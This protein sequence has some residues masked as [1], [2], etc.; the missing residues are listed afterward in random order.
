MHSVVFVALLCFS[1]AFGLYRFPLAKRESVKRQIIE[2][3]GLE[4]LASFKYGEFR[5]QDD[6]GYNEILKNYMNAQYYGTISVGTPAQNFEVIFDTGSSNLWVPG[7]ACRSPACWLH[8][9]FDCAKSSTCENT[10]EKFSIK[11]GSGAVNGTVAYDT[12]CIGGKDGLCIKKQGF[13]HTTSQ[14]GLTWAVGKFDGIFGMG[15]DTIAVN[16]LKTPFTNLIE[17]QQCAEPVFAFWLNRDPQN[18]VQGGELTVCG[19]DSNHYQGELTWA[20]VT[21]QAY[22]QIAVESV[23]VKGANIA[24]AFQVAVD[25]GTSLI[26][27]PSQDIKALAKAVGAV[28]IPLVNEYV[29]QCGVVD[30]LP[31]ITFKI[32]GKDFSLTGKD[33]VLEVT[34]A[35]TTLCVVGMT[36]LDIP[37]P[38]GPL[39]ILGD[40]FMGPHYTVFDKGN[41]RVGFAQAK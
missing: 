32:A 18:G 19:T 14:P 22:W 34:N 38:A 26:T 6:G 33:Y 29:V 23:S 3:E 36:E 2:K 4:S 12:V 17:N 13:A 24:T 10:N 15:Y 5:A 40:I 20:P 27:G 8:K 30:K 39:W 31:A 16:N 25:S 35:G 7:K 9:T 21:K 28:R 41:N 1:S 11:Y 37:A